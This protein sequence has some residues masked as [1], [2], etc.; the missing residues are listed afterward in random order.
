MLVC[1]I[2]WFCL[3]N[4]QRAVCGR[5]CWKLL[6]S[7]RS[8]GSWF[9]Y[10]PRKKLGFLFSQTPS[11]LPLLAVKTFDKRSSVDISFSRGLKMKIKNNLKE[12]REAK[13]LGKTELAK[14]AGVSPLTIDRIERGMPCRIKSQ[15]QIH[16]PLI[17]SWTCTPT[18]GAEHDQR[19]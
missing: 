10:E 14:L 17:R 2:A 11:L 16:N 6:Y 8:Y 13:M 19:A 7:E 9:S 15:R 12:I 18:V 4:M 5:R 1:G 3:H